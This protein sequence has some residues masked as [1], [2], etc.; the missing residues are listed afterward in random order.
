[1]K[2]NCLTT[3][4]FALLSLPRLTLIHLTATL[5]CLLWNQ[6]YLLDSFVSAND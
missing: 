6:A 2:E 4:K 1:M 3:L 5:Q